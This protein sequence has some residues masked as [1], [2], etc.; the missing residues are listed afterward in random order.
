[1]LGL[2]RLLPR[3]IRSL[4]RR[5]KAAGTARL[6][7]LPNRWLESGLKWHV[8]TIRADGDG[9]T[10]QGWIAAPKVDSPY[11]ALAVNGEPCPRQDRQPRPDV[12][13]ATPALGRLPQDRKSTRLN[14]SHL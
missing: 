2:K 1:M 3:R 10:V 5:V 8:E 12:Y 11:L 4:V 13:A 7:D 14:S 6:T 9:L